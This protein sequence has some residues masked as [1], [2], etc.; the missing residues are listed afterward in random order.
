[1][2]KRRLENKKGIILLASTVLLLIF[3]ILLGGTFLK[4]AMQL[5]Q[6][7]V[8]TAKSQSF[9]IAESGVE[10][11]VFELRQQFTFRTAITQAV[12]NSAVPPAQIGTY[13]LQFA[14]PAAGNLTCRGRP[15]VWVR[16]D[17]VSDL[18]V[19]PNRSA[20]R[21]RKSICA[22]VASF[23]QTDYFQLTMGTLNPQAG[24]NYNG[25]LFARDIGF[26]PG[27]GSINV[28]GEVHYIQSVTGW[29]NTPSDAQPGSVT[30][31][32]NGGVPLQKPNITFMGVDL[33]RFR[34]LAQNG[35]AGAWCN[36]N[37]TISG[38][39]NTSTA[40]CSGDTAGNGVIFVEGDLTISGTY[41]SNLTIVATGNITIANNLRS[42]GAV[43]GAAGN[44]QLGLF[45]GGDIK[46]GTPSG[47]F[48]IDVES[49]VLAD[50][51]KI[52]AECS[53]PDPSLCANTKGILNFTGAMSARGTQN[54]SDVPI[55]LNTYQ[56]RNYNFNQQ[57]IAN[58][59]IPFLPSS[60]NICSWEEITTD[61]SVPNCPIPV[62]AI[63]PPPP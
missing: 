19:N 24:S 29:N 15:Y 62:A 20:A 16:S 33:S 37:T 46:I 6:A 27:N 1:M 28:T 7:D 31:T 47:S 14:N 9:Y 48:N 53:D 58:N 30:I 32:G 21:I 25:N 36:G 10:R 35:S 40:I 38:A 12:S 4:V 5:K 13:Y 45:A 57:F 61:A 56:T 50:G 34:A 3:G 17:G 63:P 26:F 44:R 54:P 39:F 60:A 18:R 2:I 41:S 55:A 8:R 49:F 52:I 22:R 43:M 51:G 42:N 59:T 23:R 11:G